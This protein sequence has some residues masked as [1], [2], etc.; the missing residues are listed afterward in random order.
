MNATKAT[1]LVCGDRLYENETRITELLDKWITRIGKIVIADGWKGTDPIVRNWALSREVKIHR[2]FTAWKRHGKS[3]AYKRD[4]E[5]MAKGKPDVILA[6]P[7]TD[8][9]NLINLG[10]KKGIKVIDISDTGFND[11]KNPPLDL[12]EM[13]AKDREELNRQGLMGSEAR[14]GSW[15]QT[16]ARALTDDE[17]MNR[18]Y[19]YYM[20]PDADD[21]DESSNCLSCGSELSAVDDQNGE[22]TCQLC[23]MEDEEPAMRGDGRLD[24]I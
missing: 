18:D 16:R 2:F 22:S 9:V 23:M 4:D 17:K 11:V 13:D 14:E 7:G 15:E 21:V 1:V 8:N 5:M 12:G 6:F 19:L 3:A 10:I 24:I 20:T